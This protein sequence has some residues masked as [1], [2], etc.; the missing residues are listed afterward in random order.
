MPE[1]T[2]EHLL[3]IGAVTSTTARIW[4]RSNKAE[5]VT[6]TL[7]EFDHNT[8]VGT[9]DVA[10]VESALY[11]GVVIFEHL[12]PNT[13]YW[14]NA[15]FDGESLESGVFKTFPEIADEPFC[16]M[17]SSC[18]FN[19]ATYGDKQ[20]K[21]AFD[22]MNKVRS[23]YSPRF[24]IH[25]GDQVYADVV[26]FLPIHINSEDYKNAYMRTW[27][28]KNAQQFFASIP[29]FMILDDHELRN[30]FD[31][32]QSYD[33]AVIDSGLKQFYK[34]YQHKHNPETPEDQYW[35][36]FNYGNVSFFLMD[37]RTERYSTKGRMISEHQ[38]SELLKWMDDNRNNKKFI[39][40]PVPFLTEIKEAG[41]PND[42]W[43][44]IDFVSQR[45]EIVEHILREG[46]QNVIF[47]SGDMHS[48]NRSKVKL[49]KL[50]KTVYCWEFLSG[51]I[52]Q[53]V[54]NGADF[55]EPNI[56]SLE[57][58]NVTIEYDCQTFSKE[59]RTPA[60]VPKFANVLLVT[61]EQHKI[62]FAWKT[63]QQ[64]NEVEIR[65]IEVDL[66]S[67]EEV[68]TPVL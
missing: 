19:R 29:N 58:P 9:M 33:S 66:N 1:E 62:I 47:L 64:D 53:A 38:L 14:C 13:S 55:F 32:S 60:N 43:C 3:H 35:Y 18:N 39:V 31:R 51:P 45:T 50:D 52:N 67:H 28:N 23:N 57:I 27:C 22:G 40:T 48:I 7:Y 68:I 49:M 46:H 54:V 24:M 2:I 8:V 11:C 20:S 63:I 30:D 41:A 44:G 15:E 25:A 26:E 12:N 4:I 36:K 5:T 6:V 21:A 65:K 10:L 16:F 37:I 34:S 56:S 61:V 59:V 42:K 17:I